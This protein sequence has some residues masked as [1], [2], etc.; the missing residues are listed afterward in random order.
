MP[1]AI[2][3][4]ASCHQPVYVEA[5]V[6]GGC[7]CNDR[8]FRVL[9]AQQR[10]RNNAGS[11]DFAAAFVASIPNLNEIDP[12]LLMS[13][14]GRS[15]YEGARQ[16]AG[17]Q[18]RP[19]RGRT[20]VVAILDDDQAFRASVPDERNEPDTVSFDDGEGIDLDSD[21][22]TGLSQHTA[23]S[24]GHNARVASTAARMDSVDLAS[25]WMQGTGIPY[26]PSQLIAPG[27]DGFEFDTGDFVVDARDTPRG[28][29]G[30][31]GARFRVDGGAP[32]RTPFNRDLVNDQGP[33]TEAARVRGGRFPILREV[34]VAPRIQAPRPPPPPV[35]APVRPAPRNA[36]AQAREMQSRARGPSVYDLIRS[37]PLRT[38]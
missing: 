4:C 25:M 5:N 23:Q 17:P 18:G 8:D 28:G 26:D 29:G 13:A 30:G 14:A 34:M 19:I 38:K 20:E 6:Q 9:L 37:N 33:M 2:D 27:G 7:D 12:G 32:P 1:N 10:Q 3:R 35:E 21:D 24:Q 15:E 11:P 36:I 31:S 16:L 22:W